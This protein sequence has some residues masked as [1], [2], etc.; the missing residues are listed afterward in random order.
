MDPH[1]SEQKQWSRKQGVDNLKHKFKSSES[2]PFSNLIKTYSFNTTHQSGPNPHL[3]WHSE[4]LSL[5]GIQTSNSILSFKIFPIFQIS[6]LLWIPIYPF[7]S[8]SKWN[9]LKTSKLIYYL[10]KSKFYT[11][12]SKV[13]EYPTCLNISTLV[14]FQHTTCSRWQNNTVIT[15][16]RISNMI[17]SCNQSSL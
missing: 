6:M 3:T 10:D 17:R 13:Q 5:L 7:K 2:Q 8:T 4:S 1:K 16:Q 12:S 11:S 9:C 15:I 14:W